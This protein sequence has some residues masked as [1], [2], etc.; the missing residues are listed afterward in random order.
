MTEGE[1]RYVIEHLKGN[2]IYYYLKVKIINRF[3][4]Q[5][6]EGLILEN[7]ISSYLYFYE[8]TFFK[9]LTLCTAYTFR[10]LAV[11]YC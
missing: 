10:L 9:M 3:G 5:V 8:Q 7:I 4:L 6:Q 2:K 11:A 1:L